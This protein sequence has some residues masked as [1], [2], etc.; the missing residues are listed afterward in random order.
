MIIVD[1]ANEVCYTAECGN[2]YPASM[3]RV[4]HTSRIFSCSFSAIGIFSLFN[5]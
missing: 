5:D 3:R 2:K 4:V 1:A